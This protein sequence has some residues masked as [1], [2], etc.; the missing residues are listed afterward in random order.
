MRRFSNIK[1]FTK[2]IAKDKFKT[3]FT[4][5]D[6][7][8]KALF[9]NQAGGF[10]ATFLVICLVLIIYYSAKKDIDSQERRDWISGSITLVGTLLWWFIYQ[11]FDGFDI[12]LNDESLLNMGNSRKILWSFELLTFMIPIALMWYRWVYSRESI[13]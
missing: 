4:R 10:M 11:Q 13:F 5:L 12:V 2:N 3:T 7:V 8:L 9:S 6:N 1:N